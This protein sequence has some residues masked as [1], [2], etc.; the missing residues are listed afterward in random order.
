MCENPANRRPAFTLVELLV[1]VGIISVLMSIVVPSVAGA[2]RQSEMVT[3]KSNLR[4]IGLIL[5]MYSNDNKG[6][7]FPVSA[8]NST[9][10]PGGLGTNVPLTQRW[11]TV[12]FRPAI[13]NPKVMRCP[14]DTEIGV[15]DAQDPYLPIN[16][17]DPWLNKHSYILN[18]H[19]V[20]ENIR[21]GLGRYPVIAGQI[22]IAGEKK[23]D[24]FDY[25]MECNVDAK[26]A[27]YNSTD[28]ER[29]EP[30][31]H[32]LRGRSNTLY[33]DLHV[34]NADPYTVVP[35]RY[36]GTTP[37]NPVYF[38]PWQVAPQPVPWGGK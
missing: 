8:V 29:V 9:G 15:M 5:L 6:V 25:Y 26:N 30:Y 31:R 3:C 28:F 7:P 12:C 37:V 32:G 20:Y 23:T 11:T 36:V 16:D 1:V 2:R 34:D 19:L 14:I 35:G 27:V 10:Y 21:F 22:V 13:P 17:K 24:F 4:Q 18:K 33:L 38:D